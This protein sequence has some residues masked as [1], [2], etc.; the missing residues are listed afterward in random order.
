MKLNCMKTNFKEKSL[1]SLR[2]KVNMVLVPGQMG[3][4]AVTY[5]VSLFINFSFSTFWKETE[6]AIL[7]DQELLN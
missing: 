7:Q 1:T 5:Y 3:R 2:R 4:A 6:R